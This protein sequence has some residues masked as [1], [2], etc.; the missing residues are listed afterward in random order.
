[1]TISTTRPSLCN[2]QVRLL[3]VNW[4]NSIFNSLMFAGDKYKW[5]KLK[6][7]GHSIGNVTGHTAIAWKD[8]IWVFGG[9]RIDAQSFKKTV[10]DQLWSLDSSPPPTLSTVCQGLGLF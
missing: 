1:M 9:F 2:P 10:S 5:T 6:T 4:S 8:V 3:L 7:T